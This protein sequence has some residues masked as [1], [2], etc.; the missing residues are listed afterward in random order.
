[1][2]WQPAGAKLYQDKCTLPIPSS[3]LSAGCAAGAFLWAADPVTSNWCARPGSLLASE[4]L[5]GDIR[6]VLVEILSQRLPEGNRGKQPASVEQVVVRPPI[7]AGVG[8]KEPLQ[9]YQ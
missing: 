1:M 5:S 7:W 8:G 9:N 3:W 4:G 2:S 6:F